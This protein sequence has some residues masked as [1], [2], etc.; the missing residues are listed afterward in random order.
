MESEAD[1]ARP[2][3]ARID[4]VENALGL[5]AAI[6]QAGNAVLIADRDGNITYVNAAFTRMTGYAS[7]EVI[8][9][10]PRILRSGRHDTAYYKDLWERIAAGGNW[11]GELINRRKDGS[12][13][14]EEMT[15]APVLDSTGQYRALR[16]CQTGRHGTPEIGGRSQIPCRDCDLVAGRDYRNDAGRDRHQLEQRRPEAMYGYRAKEVSGN[17]SR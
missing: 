1:G 13:Y 3:A 4:T 5:A 11:Q 2:Q 16:G 7:D 10:N 15:I 14:T 9:R 17:R 8:G 12:L 6:D